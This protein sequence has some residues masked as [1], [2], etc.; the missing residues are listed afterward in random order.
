MLELN[1]CFSPVS[2]QAFIKS[3]IFSAPICFQ[4]TSQTLQPQPEQNLS[5]PHNP[6]YFSKAIRPAG[7]WSYCLIPFVCFMNYS[8]DRNQELFNTL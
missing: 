2:L 8:C 3:F 4:T 1:Q 7:I 5:S 6:F